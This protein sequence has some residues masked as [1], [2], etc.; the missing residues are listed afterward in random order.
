[1]HT[2]ALCTVVCTRGERTAVRNESAQAVFVYLFESAEESGAP[3]R[4][5]NPLMRAFKRSSVQASRDT[6]RARLKQAEQ[7]Q[8]LRAAVTC[9]AYTRARMAQL[10][11]CINNFRCPA[12]SR[13]VSGAMAATLQT[14]QALDDG[15]AAAARAAAL[16]V[17]ADI[18]PGLTSPAKDTRTTADPAN[19]SSHR[20]RAP[21]G[22][23][24][25]RQVSVLLLPLAHQHW[26]H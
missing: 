21:D 9:R 11:N 7:L 3:A 15:A 26:Q 17:P 12:V 22:L 16:R 23:A 20:Q 4:A 10:I 6:V 14:P 24:C 13:A 18:T 1:M 5:P 2:A 8:V 25:G 19:S